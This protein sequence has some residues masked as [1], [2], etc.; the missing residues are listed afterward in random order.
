MARYV[1]AET[2]AIYRKLRSEGVLMR[3]YTGGYPYSRGGL[4]FRSSITEP[5]YSYGKNFKKF[6]KEFSLFIWTL[7]KDQTKIEKHFDKVVRRLKREQVIEVIN[8][9][10]SFSYVAPAYDS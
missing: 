7:E 4:L 1:E 6:G 8:N 10:K 2:P 5:I 9:I 3:S